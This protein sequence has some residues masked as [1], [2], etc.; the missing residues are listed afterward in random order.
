MTLRRAFLTVAVSTAV[1][2]VVGI[3]LGI[4]VGYVAPDYYRM[5]F[6]GGAPNIDMVQV[7]IGNGVNAGV[8]GGVVIGLVIVAIVAYFELRSLDARRLQLPEVKHDE[9]VVSVGTRSEAVTVRPSEM[10]EESK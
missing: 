1:C 6:R 2:T 10:R 5:Q 3:G 7:G 9:P 8:A 4:F